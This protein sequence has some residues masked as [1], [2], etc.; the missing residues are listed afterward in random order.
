MAITDINVVARDAY[1]D[2]VEQLKRNLTASGVKVHPGAAYKLNLVN[3]AETQRTTSYTSSSR[4]AE[5]ELTTRVNYQII[6]HENHILLSDYAEV[7]NSVVHDSSNLAGSDTETQQVRKEMRGQLVQNL[8]IRLQQITP[9]QL[10][11]LQQKADDRAKAEQ[12]A[13]DAAQRIEDSTPKQSPL[14]LPSK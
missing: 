4:S 6:G 1:G 10:D 3:E 14:E 12:D 9:T 13:L 11:D 7:N 8:M 2:I 5:Y